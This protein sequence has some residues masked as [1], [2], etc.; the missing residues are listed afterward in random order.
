MRFCELLGKLGQ[1]LWYRE[2][3]GYYGCIRESA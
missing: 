3:R 2:V 1:V